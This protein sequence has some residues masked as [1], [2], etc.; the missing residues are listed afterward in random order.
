M[1]RRLYFKSCETEP[2]FQAQGFHYQYKFEANNAVY[3]IDQGGRMG[4]VCR[5]NG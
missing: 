4:V 1:T 2:G 3:C 5:Y